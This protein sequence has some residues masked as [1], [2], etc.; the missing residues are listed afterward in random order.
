MGLAIDHLAIN[1]LEQSLINKKILLV[2]GA[3]GAGKSQLF[4]N[5]VAEYSKA[6]R[7]A[8]LILGSALCV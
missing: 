7:N 8:I 2:T 4:A 3:A 5:T 6:G 1:R